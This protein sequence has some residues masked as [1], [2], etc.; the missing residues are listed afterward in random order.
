MKIKQKIKFIS[1]EIIGILVIFLS[2]CFKF[3]KICY[4]SVQKIGNGN[5]KIACIGD[6]ITYGLGVEFRRRFSTYPARLYKNLGKDYKVLNYGA[7]SRTLLSSGN[8]PYSKTKFIKKCLK[9]NPNIII[10]M[11]GSNDSKLINWNA[12]KYKQEYLKLIKKYQSIN[13]NF[14]IYIMTPPRAFAKIK[15]E[16]SIRNYIIKN[17]ICPIIKSI[18]KETNVKLIDLYN[19]TKD[20][21]QW[22][23]DGI[24]PNKKG[25]IEIAKYIS[26]II[27]Y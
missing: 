24:H 18:S 13:K 7:S 11:L 12:K 19:L 17:E 1:K 16:S 2:I 14:K 20:K 22:F 26:N 25:N 21:P 3:Y 8:H 6:S 15:N 4:P 5:I 10:I 27:K 23:F 9:E